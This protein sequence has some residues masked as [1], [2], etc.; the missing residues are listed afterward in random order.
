MLSRELYRSAWPGWLDAKCGQ[1]AKAEEKFSRL[2]HARL[3]LPLAIQLSV[4]CH[5]PGRLR[6]ALALWTDLGGFG[7]N[8]ASSGT[9]STVA[10]VPVGGHVVRSSAAA[11]QG[12]HH[13]PVAK[14]N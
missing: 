3:S 11:R 5:K 10:R 14:L 12:R 6:I 8:Q 9:L 13:D 2:A 7:N 4:C 1:H